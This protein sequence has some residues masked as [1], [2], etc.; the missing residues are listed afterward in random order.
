MA[1]EK[2]IREYLAGPELVRDAVAGMNQN[3]LRATPIR[4]K[5]S[6]Q[7]LICHLADF[8]PIY[9]D[10][11]KRVIAEDEPTLFGG[12][13]DVF[14]A[15]LAYTHRDVEEELLVIEAIRNQMGRI[16]RSLK[17][18]DF[19]RRGIHSDDGPLTV[20]TLLERITEHIPHHLPFILEKR[21]VLF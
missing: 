15:R 20:L 5:W 6:I 7:Q 3:Q 2:L 1:F 10:R 17:T 21:K 13:P 11:M 16:L 14:A 19:Q 8:E 9:A 18:E 12:D 4:G